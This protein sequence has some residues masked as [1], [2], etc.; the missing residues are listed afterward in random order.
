MFSHCIALGEDDG[1]ESSQSI[2]KPFLLPETPR[3]AAVSP[4]GAAG[5]STRLHKIMCMHFTKEPRCSSTVVMIWLTATFR[6]VSCGRGVCGR[7]R[8]NG[9]ERLGTLRTAFGRNAT[10]GSAERVISIVRD[11]PGGFRQGHDATC[12]QDAATAA[13]SPRSDRRPLLFDRC[14]CQAGKDPATCLIRDRLKVRRF[15]RTTT[16]IRDFA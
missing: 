12:R 4:A 3:L 13:P 8:A 9:S 5:T 1:R 7:S 10:Q 15:R 14:A 6:P 11:D 16:C 2:Q